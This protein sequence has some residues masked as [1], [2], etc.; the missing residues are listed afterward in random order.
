MSDAMLLDGKFYAA[1]IKAQIRD[2]VQALAAAGKTCSLAVLLVGED[3]AS[4]T[5]VRGKEKDCAE[6][7]IASQVLRFPADV[8]A[9]TLEQHIAD[10]NADGSVNGILIQLP[11]PAH[12]DADALLAK[13]DPAKDVD[14]ITATSMGN[15]VLGRDGFRP[16]T[17]AG[18]LYLLQA[19]GVR[20][21]GSRAVVLGRSN[22]VGKPMAA[23]LTAQNATVTLCHSK[24][25]NLAEICRSADILVAAIGKP[26]FVTA[27]MVKPGAAV[28]DVG[29]NRLENGKLC[30][31]VDFDAVSQVA[32]CI[33]P[34]PGGVGLMTRAM[35]MHNTALAA[36][37]R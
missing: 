37:N 26:R 8:S 20:L 31:D 34:V 7:G 13:I 9:Q 4:A 12:L 36:E 10:L 28:I 1:Q 23:L 30:G 33:T 6:C 25:E 3:P 21:A 27:D 18:C 5:Y 19:A 32:G 24:T 2:R 15:L 11:L 22:I 17:P 16:C 14:G 29:I 35:L